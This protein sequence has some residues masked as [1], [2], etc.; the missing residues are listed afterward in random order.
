MLAG[1]AAARRPGG[2]VP[3]AGDKDV[4]LLEGVGT[5]L[6]M[7]STWRLA[8]ADGADGAAALAFADEVALVPDGAPGASATPLEARS[9]FDPALEAGEG[10]AWA[11]SLGGGVS[12]RECPGADGEHRSTLASWARTGQWLEPGARRRLNVKLLRLGVPLRVLVDEHSMA[13]EEVPP[14]AVEPEPVSPRAETRK[15]RDK[16]RRKKKATRRT[17]A[18]PW[19]TN[20][21]KKGDEDDE[22]ETSSSFKTSCLPPPSPPEIPKGE[23]ALV[24]LAA[25]GGKIGARAWLRRVGASATDDVASFREAFF[26]STLNPSESDAD[27][28][29][30]F[31]RALEQKWWVLHRLELA[32]P[33]GVETW[34]F[35]AYAVDDD[36]K[37]AQPRV[38]HQTLPGGDRCE[39]EL[40]RTSVMKT[41]AVSQNARLDVSS[42]VT[43]DK[44]DKND[45]DDI[46][47]FDAPPE[48]YRGGFD[49]RW[50]RVA[51]VLPRGAV[52]RAKEKENL[53]EEEQTKAPPSTVALL[54]GRGDGGHVLLRPSVNGVPAPGWFAIDTSSCGNA[55]DPEYAD[56]LHMP[57]FGR[58]AVVGAAAASLAGA[59]RR[60]D[61]VDVG[62]CRVT[63]PLFME[64]A[65][66]GAMRCPA[67]TS[68]DSSPGVSDASNGSSGR[69]LGT[70]GT[71]FLQHCVLEIRAPKRV[72]GSPKPAAFEI[73]AHDPAAFAANV[74]ARVAV[75][76]QRLT[77]ISGAPHVRARVFVADDSL[78]PEPPAERKRSPAEPRRSFSSTHPEEE[79]ENDT[80]AFD[81]RLFRLALGAGG[82]GAIVAHR[83]AME[84]RMVERTVGLQPGGVLSAAGEDRARFARVDEEVVTGRL[85]RLEFRGAAFDTVRAL[86]HTRGDPPDLG[87]SPHVDGALCADLFRGCDV[88]LDLANDRVAVVQRER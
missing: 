23:G 73:L 63:S 34:V 20:T 81:G 54:A 53:A 30:N 77:W 57:A 26:F 25:R 28:E 12:R 40:T 3:G 1:A 50:P 70:L 33:E 62:A 9:G 32:L 11:E 71:D 27:A 58:L 61:R 36:A 4:V 46:V 29:R 59:F 24:A 84:W 37:V 13:P 35:D 55:I 45:A 49:A 69:L 52:D 2:V 51:F 41:R 67:L 39:F 79:D 44:N 74:P 66:A 64:Q 22:E 38:A 76:W 15:K 72:P 60:C 86:T 88:V 80:D 18:F 87:F 75:A 43:E 78:S 42:A 56:A 16:R 8:F 82:T 85:A 21:N 68:D 6:G 83:A 14:E 47:S 7:R 48:G 65:L 31:S 5:H 10:A 17:R 19:D